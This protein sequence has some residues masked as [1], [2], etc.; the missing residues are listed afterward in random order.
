[1]LDFVDAK[2][3]LGNLLLVIAILA[4]FFV[5]LAPFNWPLFIIFLIFIFMLTILSIENGLVLLIF[6]IIFGTYKQIGI[7]NNQAIFLANIVILPILLALFVRFLFSKEKLVFKNKLFCVVFLLIA[8]YMSFL[9]AERFFHFLGVFQSPLEAFKSTFFS[10]N[11]FFVNMIESF[12]LTGLLML[13]RKFDIEKFFN[14]VLLF[15]VLVA[16]LGLFQHFSAINFPFDKGHAGYIVNENFARAYGTFNRADAYGGFHNVFAGFL[17]LV[18]P[19]VLILYIN[20]PDRKKRSLLAMA[21]FITAAGLFSTISRAGMLA[22]SSVFVFS[23]IYYLIKGNN[24]TKKT[25]GAAF[26]ILLIAIIPF[27]LNGTLFER[28]SGKPSPVQSLATTSPSDSLSVLSD[29]NIGKRWFLYESAYSI[30]QD[31][32]WFGIGSWNYKHASEKYGLSEDDIRSFHNLYLQIW[33]EAG[34]VA[35]ALFLATLLL[36]LIVCFKCYR[37]IFVLASFASVLTFALHNLFDNFFGHGIQFLFAI[38]IAIPFILYDRNETG[39]R[40]HHSG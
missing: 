38:L 10:H 30:I 20:Q 34:I 3:N 25:L 31:N 33:V 6:F 9:A 1:M 19:F 26:I 24:H 11:R 35:L 23:V 37:N 32:F 21:F 4:S 15:T 36:F 5:M 22:F 7:L 13:V 8:G 40:F 14:W 17:N 2:V 27:V 29:Q 12:S 18:V 28:F 39:D 16:L